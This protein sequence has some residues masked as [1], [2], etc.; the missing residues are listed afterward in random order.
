MTDRRR[1]GADLSG[2]GLAHDA[3]T[4]EFAGV[5]GTPA[6]GLPGGDRA[7]PGR[8]DAPEIDRLA[9][10]LCPAGCE[11]EVRRLDPSP[12]QGS[13]GPA[14]ALPPPPGAVGA[15]T[16]SGRDD[17]IEGDD[18]QPIPEPEGDACARARPTIREGLEIHGHRCDRGAGFAVEEVLRPLRNLAASVPLAGTPDRLVSVRLNGRIPREWI[19]P[20]LAV[21]SKLRPAAPIRRGQVLLANVLGTG[22][23]VVATRS[24]P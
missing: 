23:D 17:D 2:A 10:I 4:R 14:A 20:V 13:E 22:V 18:G 9:C 1:R 19:F 3:G 24:E 21:I 5:P 11:L 6:A 15:E 7:D 12:R 16:R 8:E